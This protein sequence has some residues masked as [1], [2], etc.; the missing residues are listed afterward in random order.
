MEL[1]KLTTQDYVIKVSK[2]ILGAIPFA[3]ALLGELMEMFIVP[4]QQEKM[5]EWFHHVEQTLEEV[6]EK[7]N[8]SK[9]EIFNDENFTSIFQKTSRVYANNV[10]ALKKPLLQSY[11]RAS[12]TKPIPLDKKYIFLDIID[13]LTESQL[14]ILKE[15]YENHKSD[16]FKY[17]TALEETLSKKFTGGDKQ[18]L[19]LLVKGLQNYHLLNY[20][21]TE[22]IIDNAKQWYMVPSKIAN[23]FIEFL[24]SD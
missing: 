5:E 17:Q 7:G 4:Q 11:L 3:G 24:A 8:Q 16:N 20:G 13:K 19:N 15:I 23:E 18:Y 22:V 10:E 9:E 21:G 1:P 14:L 2:G 6:L 12:I